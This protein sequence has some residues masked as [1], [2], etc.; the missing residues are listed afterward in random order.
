MRANL[1]QKTP[2]TNQHC[3]ALR[4][5]VTDENLDEVKG[6]RAPCYIVTKP[7]RQKRVYWCEGP[8]LNLVGLNNRPLHSPF[9]PSCGTCINEALD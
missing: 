1:T 4:Q 2:A 7:S 9:L 5:P 8:S 6:P 3:E